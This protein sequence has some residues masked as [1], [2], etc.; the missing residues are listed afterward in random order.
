MSYDYLL[1]KRPAHLAATAAGE[2]ETKVLMT[3][4]AEAFAGEA[5]GSVDAVKSS[6]QKLFPALRW[7]QQKFEIAPHLLFAEL[8]DWSWSTASAPDLPQFSLGADAKGQVRAISAS[9]VARVELEPV[10]KALGLLVLD[11]QALEILT[12]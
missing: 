6:L 12:G 7:H 1:I 9:S 5:I 11:E 4:F 10:A 8:G 2:A 3:A